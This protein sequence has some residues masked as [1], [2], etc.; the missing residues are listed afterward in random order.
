M[1]KQVPRNCHCVSRFLTKPWEEGQRFLR[2]YDFDTNQFERRSSRSLF[3]AEDV[4]SPGVEGWLQRMVEDPLGKIRDRVV[5]GERDPLEQDWSRFRAALLLIL[6]QGGRI[7]TIADHDARRRLD[8]I[9]AMPERELDGLVREAMRRFDLRLVHTVPSAE[10]AGYAPLYVP[11]TG[12]FPV[13]VPE[14]VFLGSP[15]GFGIPIALTCALVV[16]PVEWPDKLELHQTRTILS[17]LSIGTSTARRVVVMPG[18]YEQKGEATLR[19]L[20]LQARR[21][22]ERLVSVVEKMRRSVVSAFAEA[23]SRVGRG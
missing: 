22:N 18:M 3:A 1:T 17:T 11:S 16:T 6:L 19:E 7:A 14:L 9:A 2:Y 20:L 8:V 10:R 21:D 15:F 5:R 23:E 13:V 4:N 12:L